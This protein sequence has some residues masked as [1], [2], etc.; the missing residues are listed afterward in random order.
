MMSRITNWLDAHPAVGGAVWAMIV[1]TVGTVF[2]ALLMPPV[3]WVFGFYWRL[4]Q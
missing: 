1:V 3:L 4:W 2:M